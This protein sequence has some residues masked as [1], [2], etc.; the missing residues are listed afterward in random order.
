MPEWVTALDVEKLV[1]NDSEEPVRVKIP[2]DIE[3]VIEAV[4]PVAPVKSTGKTARSKLTFGAGDGWICRLAL[5]CWPVTC[6][7]ASW[8]LK[9]E[10]VAPPPAS[11]LRPSPSMLIVF[12][13]VEILIPLVPTMLDRLGAEKLNF[14]PVV[15]AMVKAPPAT[16]M[17]A[18]PLLYVV[19]ELASAIPPPPP[20][21]PPEIVTEFAF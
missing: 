4:E 9:Y 17:F 18:V 13:A 3:S 20:P 11:V 5:P 12:P 14:C 8:G 21:A 15:E 6:K 2:S 10:S 19:C 1:D 7:Y 16:S